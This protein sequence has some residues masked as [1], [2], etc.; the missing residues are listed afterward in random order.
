MLTHNA[1][2]DLSGPSFLLL[3]AAVIA[4]TL[5]F[6]AWSRNRLDTTDDRRLPLVPTHPDPFEIAFLR[7]GANEVTRVAVFG[8]IQR[9]FLEARPEKPGKKRP[10]AFGTPGT[11]AGPVSFL[12]LLERD[13]LGYF[14]APRA[15]R[16]IFQSGLPARLTSYCAGYER[17]LRGE[18]LLAGD[19]DRAD[20]ARIGWTGCGSSRAGQLQTGCGARQR[21]FQRRV[22]DPDGPRLLHHPRRPVPPAPPDPAR[23]GLPR[24]SPAGVRAPE[25]S[26]RRQGMDA[27]PAVLLLSVYGVGALAGNAARLLRADVRPVRPAAAVGAAAGAVA[28]EAAVG[29]G[30]GGCGVRRR[31]K[32]IQDDRKRLRRS[33]SAWAS[34]PRFWA[35]CSCIG[36]AWTF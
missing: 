27:D 4:L 26:R 10:A 31:L 12:S 13:V 23:A 32:E 20:R 35:T 21:P 17:T 8:L 7:G 19:E 25:T 6:C 3:Y 30:G 24:A 2:A 11:A 29:G 15:A 33:A 5:A 36:T 34:A 1:L 16:D 18:R 9:G 22:P 14:T 28:A